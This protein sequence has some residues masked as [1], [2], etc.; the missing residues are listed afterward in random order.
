MSIY[1]AHWRTQYQGTIKFDK[2][3][4]QEVPGLLASA[5]QKSCKG[6]LSLALAR[7]EDRA[8]R[9]RIK[10]K[11][12]GAIAG[13]RGAEWIACLQSD[14]WLQI[15][16]GERSLSSVYLYM[17]HAIGSLQHRIIMNK[18]RTQLFR[19]AICSQ[20]PHSIVSMHMSSFS[21]SVEKSA[22]AGMQEDGGRV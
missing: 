12:S 17:F 16:R 21:V 14:D 15:V 1:L 7:E 8:R 9:P 4:M 13:S 3:L 2:V 20:S 18:T 5:T 10:R 19:S 11:W 22:K 6:G